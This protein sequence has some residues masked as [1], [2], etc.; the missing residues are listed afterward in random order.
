MVTSATVTITSIDG[1]APA[2]TTLISGT[3]GL[4]PADVLVC[5]QGQ[6]GYDEVLRRYSYPPQ[7]ILSMKGEGAQHTFEGILQVDDGSTKTCQGALSF[8][9][10]RHLDDALNDRTVIRA[11]RVRPGASH[12][13]VFDVSSI[14]EAPFPGVGST[15]KDSESTSQ[16]SGMLAP[17]AQVSYDAQSGETNNHW[18]YYENTQIT[19][20]LDTER[21]ILF[22]SNNAWT[23]E[24]AEA[25]AQHGNISQG[26]T[27]VLVKGQVVQV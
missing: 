24:D 10:S 15:G 4:G 1:E 9:H 19:T 7:S 16:T 23:K 12:G 27:F 2:R 13:A 26:Q 17:S 25:V 14:K 22:G 20:K 6:Y 3:L 11:G 21:S 8:R 5:S 18:S